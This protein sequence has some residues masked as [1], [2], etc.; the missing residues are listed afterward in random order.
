[1]VFHSFAASRGRKDRSE[2]RGG[3]EDR[4]PKMLNKNCATPARESD[5]KWLKTGTPG[6]LFE[7]DL[8]KNCTTPVRV[9][10]LEVKIVKNWQARSTFGS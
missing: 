3:A 7:V 5:S 10:D 1:M 9:S 4:L 8:E 2:K 6:T